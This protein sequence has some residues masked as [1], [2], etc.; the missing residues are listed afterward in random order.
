MF[1]DRRIPFMN[2][3][4]DNITM[5]EAVEKIHWLVERK[6]PSYVVTPNVDHI[7][8]LERDKEFKAVYDNADLILA[9]GKPLLWLSKFYGK[10]IREKISGSD[11]FPKVCDMAA[12]KGFSIFLLGAAEG[13]ADIAASNLRDKYTGLNVVG[14]YSP[15]F[16]FEE[17]DD[18][19][20]KII[21]L[22]N[23]ANPDILVVGLGCPKQEKFMYKYLD[24]LNVPVSLGLGAS[25]DFEAGVV[26]R[27]PRWMSNVGLEWFYRFMR[28]PKRLMKRYF[29]D[30]MDIFRLAVK[31]R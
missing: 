9:D 12:L 19:V 29:I 23:E 7:V 1:K 21:K 11:L 31:Y 24:F 30:D 4:L 28:E 13:V 17:S 10:P 18:E 27:A 14:T 3:M 5:E 20:D 15:P 26:R 16:G 25:I 6:K 22:V 2:T 8:K